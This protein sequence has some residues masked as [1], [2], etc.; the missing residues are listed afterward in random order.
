MRQGLVTFR[1]LCEGN[2]KGAELGHE[3]RQ[4]TSFKLP[5][6]YAIGAPVAGEK[7]GAKKAPPA[8]K[9]KEAK[10]GKNEKK[11]PNAPDE[12]ELK[13]LEEERL[14]REA[15]ALEAEKERIQAAERREHPHMYMWLKIKAKII[16]ILIHQRRVED[17]ADVLAVTHLESSAINDKFFSRLLMEF[18]F[19]MMV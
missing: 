6:A 9:K 19:K 16:E 3:E 15:E 13:R 10:G 14:A 7:G 8:E 1:D 11:D 18:D 17:C 4:T 2:I 12:A 5:D